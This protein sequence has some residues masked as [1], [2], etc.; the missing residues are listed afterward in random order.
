VPH[1]PQVDG[2]TYR[3]LIDEHRVAV[4]D[5]SLL[6]NIAGDAIVTGSRHHQAIARVADSLRVVGRAPDGV[7]EA[8]EAPD[9]TAF[10]LAVQWHPESTTTLD[11]GASAALFAALVASARRGEGKRSLA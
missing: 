1:A 3:G 7:V 6:A 8:L 4:E 11:A 2:A 5:G 10:W 9:A